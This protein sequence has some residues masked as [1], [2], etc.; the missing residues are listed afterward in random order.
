MP[1]KIE[2]HEYDI[3]GVITSQVVRF[4]GVEVFKVEDLEVNKDAFNA[5]DFLNA[6]QLGLDISKNGVKQLEITYVNN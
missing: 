1:I 4:N 2:I 3:G 6:V 5:N